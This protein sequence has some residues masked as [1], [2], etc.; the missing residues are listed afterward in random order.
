MATDDPLFQTLCELSSDSVVRWDADGR[1]VQ[2]E[3]VPQD[4]IQSLEQAR[5]K[6]MSSGLRIEGT[7]AVRIQGQSILFHFALKATHGSVI[8]VI[9][10]V[11]A[12]AWSVYE[13]LF[14]QN[15][16][17]MWIYDRESLRF[18]D[19]NLSATLHYGFSREEFLRMTL[20]QIRS[21]EEAGRFQETPI[22]HKNVA[23]SGAWT[24]RSKS[25]EEF[26]VEIISY[27]YNWGGRKARL[28]HA[29]NIE[30]RKQ[31]KEELDD[32]NRKLQDLASRA[33]FVLPRR[34]GSR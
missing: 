29:Y 14:Q 23:L 27:D 16:V 3:D 5:L 17:P 4:L 15:P 20:L 12:E 31:L 11:D 9:R 18:L 26:E 24:H 1:A 33:L 19:V 28:V 7:A 25:G 8:G 32:A 10:P 34:G 2:G 13:K 21:S 6:A 30:E 22:P